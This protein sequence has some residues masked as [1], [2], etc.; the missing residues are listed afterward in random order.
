MVISSRSKAFADS[1]QCFT[2][3]PIKYAK[4]KRDESA[5]EDEIE[6]VSANI[7]MKMEMNTEFDDKYLLVLTEPATVLSVACTLDAKGRI[8]RADDGMALLLGYVSMRELLGVEISKLIPALQLETDI[9][10]Q[11]VCALSVPGNSI[12]VT[13]K[14]NNEKDPETHRPLM[15]E[16]EIQTFSTVSGIVILTES[17]AL[18]SFNENFIE[19][20]IGK[21]QNEALKDITVHSSPSHHIHSS[22]TWLIN[23]LTLSLPKMNASENV[24]TIDVTHSSVPH[25]NISRT[26]EVCSAT[27][28]T[29]TQLVESIQLCDKI[30]QWNDMIS[31]KEQKNEPIVE[32]S[33]CGFAKHS[34]SNLIAIC[35]NIRRLKASNGA[36]W[37]VCISFN[38]SVNF[39]ISD[40]TEKRNEA[41]EESICDKHQDICARSDNNCR[42]GFNIGKNQLTTVENEDENAQAI[43]G[44][45]SEHYDTQHLIGNGAFGSVKITARKD[46]GILA[47]AKF[48]SKAK[49][50]SESWVPSPKRNNRVVPIE[51]HLLETLSHPNIVKLLDVFENDMYYQLVME[52][53]RCGMDLF[54]FIEQQPKLDEPLISYIFRQVVSAVTYLHSKNIVHRDL[55]DE[56]VIIDQN[57][58]CKLIDFG[59]AAY[60]G[61]NLI[62]STFCGTIEYCSPEVLRGNKYR[63]PELEMWS[64]GILLYTLVFF[65]NPFRNLQEAT[66][67]R[68]QLPWEVS[69]GLFEVIVWLL[70]RD[71]QLRATI[72]DIGDHRWTKQ[73][74][75]LQK[76]KFNDVLQKYDSP[77]SI[78]SNYESELINDSTDVP[79]SS[80]GSIIGAK[81]NTRNGI[82]N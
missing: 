24:A 51:L 6:N 34:D 11:H 14:V 58:S 60:F 26:D 36:T 65:E 80:S 73:S 43:A 72:R 44:E 59:S 75:D 74:I 55:K 7:E 31:D 38:K 20:L 18:H 49:V 25:T 12:P 52:K 62:F 47:V 33:F 37:A 22:V 69:E 45:Y 2:E 19:A 50:F 27:P 17:G 81:S 1:K 71:P 21:K 32:G 10:I 76:Y 66:R 63:G 56:N 42:F 82:E 53:L 23:D 48:V 77:Q 41:I 61:H 4:L 78:P 67:A 8:F 35:F 57:F 5:E 16:L 30:Q 70:Q 54:E 28:S 46:T 68:L 39:G 13:V 15:Y 29:S 3:N 9:D 64:L 40:R 79:T